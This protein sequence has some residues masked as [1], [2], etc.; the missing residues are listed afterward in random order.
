M[1][2]ETREIPKLLFYVFLAGVAYL[3]AAKIT[4]KVGEQISEVFK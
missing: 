3:I 4:G 1:T 2:L